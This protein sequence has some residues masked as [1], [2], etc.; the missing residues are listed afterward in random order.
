MGRCILYSL[1]NSSICNNCA[2]NP[3]SYRY[4]PSKCG[5]VPG[6]ICPYDLMTSPMEK[7]RQENENDARKWIYYQNIPRP[8]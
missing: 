5:S 8:L 2:S 1:P 7:I 3:S 6:S 4:D